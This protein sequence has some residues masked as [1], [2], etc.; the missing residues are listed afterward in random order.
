MRPGPVPA[1]VP[2]APSPS[3]PERS[4]REVPRRADS[5]R[6]P[7]LATGTEGGRTAIARY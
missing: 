7:H 6:G 1:A 4:M 5:A 2:A 3:V